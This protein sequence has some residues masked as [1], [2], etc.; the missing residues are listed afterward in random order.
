M[1]STPA[2]F[3]LAPGF[4]PVVERGSFSPTVSTVSRECAKPLKRFDTATADH[5]GLKPGANEM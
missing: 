3:S 5:T 2:N 4:S 1:I